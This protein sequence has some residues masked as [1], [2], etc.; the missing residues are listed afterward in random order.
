ME[1]SCQT[2]YHFEITD[3]CIGA[4]TTADFRGDHVQ[5]YAR[6]F[7][8]RFVKE[9]NNDRNGDTLRNTFQVD[10]KNC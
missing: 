9:N 2:F 8:R 10:K 4:Y 7:N 6:R 3:I 1:K 5:P